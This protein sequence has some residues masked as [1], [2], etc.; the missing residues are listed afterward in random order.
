MLASDYINVVPQRV[1]GYQLEANVVDPEDGEITV[2]M[3]LCMKKLF[4]IFERFMTNVWENFHL[5]FPHN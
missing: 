1:S 4:V 3:F 2:R 5:D